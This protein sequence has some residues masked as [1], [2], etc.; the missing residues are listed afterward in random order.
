MTSAYEDDDDDDDPTVREYDVFVN[1]DL[2]ER[3][4][5]LQAV[6]RDRRQPYTDANH[7]KPSE[8]RIKP[9]VGL[10][11]LDIPMNIWNNY[12]R[13]K[14]LRWGEALRKSSADKAGGS[15]GLMGGFGI[16][17][18]QSSARRRTAGAADDEDVTQEM[19][20]ANYAEADAKGHVLNKQTLG[21]Q[22]VPKDGTQP[23]YMV[24]V[25][26]QDQLHLTPLDSI[27]QLRPQFHHIDAAAEQERAA[28][29]LQRE[30]IDPPRQQEARSVHMTVK[31]V[32]GEDM[33]MTETTKLLRAAQEEKWRRLDYYDENSQTAWDAYE[34]L[35]VADTDKASRLQSTMDNAAYL[36][37]ISAPDG[38]GST[39][40]KK[41]VG[42]K[43]DVHVVDE[44]T[45]VESAEET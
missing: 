44:S 14:A 23:I 32:D 34:K 37:A 22:I 2:A 42:S 4:I 18:G 33:D 13:E 38:Q 26:R 19:L 31:A 11:E 7:A 1:N 10:V 15:H 12:D 29:R 40:P 20:L 41:P 5:L 45:D 25:F 8:L 39:K 30:A 9:E 17:A 36:D 24:G 35:F 21:G 28:G 16:G 43:S 27:V 3:L 6:N